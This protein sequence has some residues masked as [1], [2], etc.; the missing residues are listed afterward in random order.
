MTV[1]VFPYERPC[2]VDNPV[3]APYESALARQ[4]KLRFGIG[5]K[6]REDHAG[7]LFKEIRRYLRV[8]AIDVTLSGR[9]DTRALGSGIFP[10]MVRAT[11][12][13]SLDGSGV[14]C[15]T[16]LRAL[17]DQVRKAVLTAEQCKLFASDAKRASRPR[18]Q[19]LRHPDRVP[20][21]RC[22]LARRPLLLDHLRR[23]TEV[24]LPTCR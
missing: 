12:S 22:P 17:A 11:D 10:T 1:P 6:V 7:V 14:Q 24:S 13:R 4:F 23:I 16:T 21:T 15:R 20:K 18:G 3:A 8:I 9:L 5:T 19:R 2:A